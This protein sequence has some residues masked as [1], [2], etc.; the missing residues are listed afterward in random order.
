VE[1][2]GRVAEGYFDE[3]SAPVEAARLVARYVT[4]A[5]ETERVEHERRSR[6]V[7]SARSHTPTSSGSRRRRVSSW[8]ERDAF[9][10]PLWRWHISAIKV[11]RGDGHEPGWLQGRL[12]L[13]PRWRQ[14][15]S[16]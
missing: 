15:T 12:G 16:T 4:D 3:R 13:A 2:R 11:A 14:I 6:G 10:E 5:R 7:T 1:R 8:H 9:L